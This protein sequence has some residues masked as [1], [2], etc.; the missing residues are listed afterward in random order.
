MVRTAP[1]TKVCGLRVVHP[2]HTQG[3]L[4]ACTRV[5]RLGTAST[6]TGVCAKTVTPGLPV[7]RMWHARQAVTKQPS[8]VRPRLSWVHFPGV[9]GGTSNH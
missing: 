9:F 7:R 6:L 2:Q 8:V 5:L 3:A 4:V 1:P